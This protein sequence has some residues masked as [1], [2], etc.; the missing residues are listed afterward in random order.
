MKNDDLIIKYAHHFSVTECGQL[1]RDSTPYPMNAKAKMGAGFDYIGGFGYKV[2]SF[3]SSLDLKRTLIRSHRVIFYIRHGYLPE[4]IDHVNRDPADNSIKNLRS[5][6]LSQNNMNRRSAKNSSSKFLG[7]SWSKTA[8]KWQTLMCVNGRDR[9]L[10][11]FT[12]E[13]EAAKAY[14]TAAAKHHGE[15]V[16]LNI[17][18]GNE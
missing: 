11:L 15:F 4:C 6:T 16:N 2:F 7:V 10:G 5:A 12:S 17:I 8:K 9:Y 18:P 3:R 1:S 14:N 13:T